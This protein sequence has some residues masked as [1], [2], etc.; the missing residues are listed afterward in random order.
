M[1]LVFSFDEGYANAFKV[2]LHSIFMSNPGRHMNIYLLHDDMPTDVLA[3][4]QES[5]DYYQYSFSRLTVENIWN[6]QKISESIVITQLK[7][8]YGYLLHTY[9]QRK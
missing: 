6:S 8:I 2:L 3:D 9:F 4:L 1:N 5:M 7:C